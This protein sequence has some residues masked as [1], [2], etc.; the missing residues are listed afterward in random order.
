MFS[1][2][3]ILEHLKFINS[4][5]LSTCPN[6]VVE[7]RIIDMLE[8]V[9]P[10]ETVAKIA[11]RMKIDISQ[12]VWENEKDEVEAVAD[13]FAKN[14]V[15]IYYLKNDEYGSDFANTYIVECASKFE[16]VIR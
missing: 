12:F 16:L 10:I 1:A 2:V 11:A 3:Q 5:D 4:A 7:H 6:T 15:K 14:I 9:F 13:E 8:E